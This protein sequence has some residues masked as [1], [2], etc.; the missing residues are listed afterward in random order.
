MLDEETGEYQKCLYVPQP[1]QEG[2]EAEEEEGVVEQQQQLV[3]DGQELAHEAQ[4]QQQQ[5]EVNH[6]GG[7]H[8]QLAI[9]GATF[10]L[11]P[12]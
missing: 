11:P 12:F 7:E 8:I 6:E 3:Q 9:Q 1:H 2:E 5:I 4:Q 10:F